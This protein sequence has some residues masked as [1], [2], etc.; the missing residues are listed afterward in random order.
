M[1]QHGKTKGSD[2]D[3]RPVVNGG[4]RGAFTLVELLVVIGVIAVLIAILLPALNKARRMAKQTRTLAAMREMMHGYLAYANDNKGRLMLGFPP[5]YV[6]GELLRVSLPTGQTIPTVGAGGY[7]SIAE[8]IKRYPARLAPYQQNVWRILYNHA[9][10]YTTPTPQDSINDA[11]YKIYILGLYPT[12]GLNS[13]FLGGDENHDGFIGATP[14]RTPNV[15]KHVA[16]RITEVRRSAEQI[17]FTEV[18]EQTAAGPSDRGYFRATPPVAG[19]RM[20]RAVGDKCEVAGGI[21]FGLPRGRSSN[22]IVTGFLDG[23]AAAI[24]AAELDD[25]RLWAPR[26]TAVDYDYTSP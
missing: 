6:N 7:G 24:G 16:F 15:G 23:H 21:Q 1:K 14:N 2:L 3:G 20:W 17:V 4:R 22:R 19:G 5:A 26:A 13:A 11:A 9:E 10:P 12:F 18:V 25:M 8:P